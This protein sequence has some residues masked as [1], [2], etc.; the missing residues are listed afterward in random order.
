LNNVEQ[1]IK[2]NNIV[3]KGKCSKHGGLAFL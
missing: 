2:N 1:L 3:R